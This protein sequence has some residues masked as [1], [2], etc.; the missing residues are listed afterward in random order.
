MPD[1]GME[2]DVTLLINEK[3]G[4]GFVRVVG[5]ATPLLCTRTGP[6]LEAEDEEQ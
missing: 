5:F 3:D 1:G 2:S 4:V 6:N